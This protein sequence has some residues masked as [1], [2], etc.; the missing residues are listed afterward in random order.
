[1]NWIE[2]KESSAVKELKRE[3]LLHP[4]RVYTIF[5][6]STRCGISR[7]AKNLFESE[8]QVAAPV[9]LVN[10]VESREVS[11]A[12][13]LLFDVDHESPQILVIKNGI[14]IHVNSHSSIDAAEVI[15]FL[16]SEPS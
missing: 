2:I 14:S 6:H 12:I 8:W 7:M 1:M 13:T 15:K 9:H 11:D 4:E 10:V 3:S 5:K 16:Q